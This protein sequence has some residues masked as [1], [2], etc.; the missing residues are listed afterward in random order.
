MIY[1]LLYCLYLQEW[2]VSQKG[3]IIVLFRSARRVCILERI[4]N[5]NVLICNEGVCPRKILLLYCFDLKEQCVSKK[6]Y[7]TVMFRIARGGGCVS[8]KGNIMH[9]LGLQGGCVTQKGHII[10]LFSSA[11]RVFILERIQYCIVARRVCILERIQ[12]CTVQI[13]KEGLYPIQNII[14]YCLDL[15]GGFVSQIEN[16]ILLFRSARRVCILERIIN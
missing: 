16:I 5:Y 13:C 1:I 14:L 11:I 3:Y 8:Q 7:I 9:C 4:Y 15:Q 10:A 6:G 12:Y 2:G